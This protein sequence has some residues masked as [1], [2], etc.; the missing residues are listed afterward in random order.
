M[1]VLFK[2][3][4]YMKKLILAILCSLLFFQALPVYAEEFE[5]VTEEI[6]NIDGLK[7][8]LFNDYVESILYP[9]YDLYSVSFYSVMDSFVPQS[10]PK[11]DLYQIWKHKVT[12]I[13][14]GQLE[15]SE[16]VYQPETALQI[17]INDINMNRYDGNGNQCSPVACLFYELLGYLQVDCPYELYWF[18]KVQG[19]SLSYVASVIENE[20]IQILKISKVTI[21][22]KV[23]VEYAKDGNR[24]TTTVDTNKTGAALQAAENALMVVYQASAWNDVEKLEYYRDYICN[25]VSYDYTASNAK[26]NRYGDPWQLIYV[27]DGDETTNVVCEGYAKAFEYLCNLTVFNSSSIS[28]IT[29]WG[30]TSGNHMWNILTMDDHENYIVDLT[31]YDSISSSNKNAFFIGYADGSIEEGYR[32]YYND[33]NYL[34]YT[35]DPAVQSYFG[36]YL[37]INS[38]PYGQNEQEVVK[39]TAIEVSASKLNLQL[40]MKSVKLNVN[41][42]PENADERITFTSSNEQIAKVDENGVITPIK[43]GKC[44]ISVSSYNHLKATCEVTVKDEMNYSIQNGIL[45]IEGT[46]HMSDWQSVEDVPWYDQKEDII[47]VYIEEGVQSIGNYFFASLPNLNR[48]Y[49]PKSVTSICESLPSVSYF[50]EEKSEV[51]SLLKKEHQKNY[52]D[53]EYSLLKGY[54]MKLDASIHLDFYLDLNE[55]SQFNKSDVVEIQFPDGAIQTMSCMEAVREEVDGQMYSVFEIDVSAKDLSQEITLIYGNQSYTYSIQEYANAIFK[56]YDVSSKEVQVMKALLT[57]GR[58]TQLYFDY[59][60]DSLPSSYTTIHTYDFDSYTLMDENDSIDFIGARLQLA[61]NLYLK[62][63][64]ITNEALYINGKKANVQQEGNYRVIRIPVDSLNS[65]YEIQASNFELQYS[66]Q[67]FCHSA[68]LSKKEALIQLTNSLIAYY[69][70]FQ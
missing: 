56:N 3:R 55:V 52:V 26:D 22:M 31:N 39:P 69:A 41:I 36:S 61:S 16:I 17:P 34:K 2:E 44:R 60:I 48:I 62:L 63:Y 21:K 29:T 15:C 20:G 68:N 30:Q 35:Y 14:N 23:N 67:N 11:Y 24:N 66:I 12:Q 10:D 46:G 50:I 6:T 38:T 53:S 28:C 49:I 4:S 57:Y 65:I 64:F 19:A 7:D 42:L 37:F 5:E 32:L 33:F 18:D 40:K 25:A 51:D 70:L 43:T 47:D 9:S 54:R 59:K 27:F 1:Q 45:R 8:D 13:A 58:Y